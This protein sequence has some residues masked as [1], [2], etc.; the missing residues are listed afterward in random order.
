MAKIP[1]SL[2]PTT[3]GSSGAVTV[4]QQKLIKQYGSLEAAKVAQLQNR[5]DKEIKAIGLDKVSSVDDY[6]AKY[7]KAS[8]EARQYIETPTEYSARTIATKEATIQSN[9]ESINEKITYYSKKARDKEDYYDAKIKRYKHGDYSAERIQRTKDKQEEYEKYYEGIIKGLEQSRGMEIPFDKI[10]DYAKDLGGYERKRER[11]KNKSRTSKTTTVKQTITKPSLTSYGSST[12]MV[13]Q[14]GQPVYADIDDINA[15]VQ[16]VYTDVAKTQP[17]EIKTTYTYDKSKQKYIPKPEREDVTVAA[18]S[19]KIES[20]PLYAPLESITKYKSGPSVAYTKSTG[21]NPLS[22]QPTVSKSG[23][24]G[25]KKLQPIRE[26]PDVVEFVKQEKI[27]DKLSEREQAKV[28][29]GLL[30]L[31]YKEDKLMTTYYN[32][33]ESEVQS[34][35]APSITSIKRKGDIQNIIGTIL[36]IGDE[37]ELTGEEVEYATSK[38]LTKELEATKKADFDSAYKAEYEKQMKKIDIKSYQDRINAGEDYDNVMTEYQ[39][40]IKTANEELSS[41]SENWNKTWYSTRGKYLEK[42]AMKV[43]ADTS[44]IFRAKDAQAKVGKHF[45]QG[46]AVGG[47]FAAGKSVIGIAATSLT[48]GHAVGTAIVAGGS[49]VIAGGALVAGGLY[50]GYSFGKAASVGGKKYKQSM[51]IGFTYVQ[52][53]QRAYVGA[54]TDL[55]PFAFSMAGAMAGSMIV[56]GTIKYARSPD[57]KPIKIKSPIKTARTGTIGD[58]AKIYTDH[59]VK[60]GAVYKHQKIAQTGVSGQRVEVSTRWRVSINK[61]LG[62]HTKPVYK[63]VPVDTK[64]EAKAIALLKSYG[65]TTPQAKASI[66]YTAPQAI[67]TY[68]DKGYMYIDSK[69]ATGKFKFTDKK[70]VIDVDKKLGIKTQ[71]GE[72]RTRIL[73]VDRASIRAE[74]NYMLFGEKAGALSF[75]H[76][77]AGS[78]SEI[79]F[80]GSHARVTLAK[81]NIIKDDSYTKITSKTGGQQFFT[82]DKTIKF[83]IS[84][85]Y[86]Y[87]TKPDT[88]T[89]KYRAGKNP[90]GAY[91]QTPKDAKFTFHYTDDYSKP[92]TFGPEV[93]TVKSTSMVGGKYKTTYKSNDMSMKD[94]S[95]TRINMPKF[96]FEPAS[97]TRVGYDS[98]GLAVPQ[99][100]F[101]SPSTPTTIVTPHTQFLDIGTDTS[102]LSAMSIDSVTKQSLMPTA[103][104]ALKSSSLIGVKELTPIILTKS[105]SSLDQSN[106]Q[107][108]RQDSTQKETVDQAEIVTSPITSP[109]A[110]PGIS[111][112][113]PVPVTTPTFAGD[114]GMSFFPE[115]P[116]RRKKKTFKTEEEIIAAYQGQVMVAGKYKTVTTA[117]HTRG[118]A[119]DFIAKMIDNTT[120][121]QGRVV[122]TDKKVKVKNIKKGDG[123]YTKTKDKFR[124]FKISGGKQIPLKDTIIEKRNRRLD[125]FGETSGMTVAQ[126]Q[127][128]SKKRA[129]G[130]PVRKT[131]RKQPFRL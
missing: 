80:G 40:E 126:F 72:A 41:F 84:R 63:G 30:N 6:T 68:L 58:R 24:V 105:S 106:L 111:P 12:P 124:G 65:Y 121:A 5:V 14:P 34:T 59:G 89:I 66:K 114:P 35:R 113:I 57:L 39:A 2:Q 36:N 45:V 83:D 37:P 50:T 9:T 118:G 64:G 17:I 123:Y 43:A 76:N 20:V 44:T 90:F 116:D 82:D 96:R 77:G 51:D 4:G 42:S 95:T 18:L 46:A 99:P 28:T 53:L 131:K 119:M 115:L 97:K 100:I 125:T 21:K 1:A 27:K 112:I 127:S 85:T 10:M 54:A 88:K 3:M 49:T 38:V 33:L 60:H 47:I 78:I 7:S 81:Q 25:P 11:V 109:I 130:I 62:G 122:K 55:S 86:L 73:N 91:E 107:N 8:A 52:S 117:P 129:A 101:S 92:N 31:G 32:K 48:A 69:H 79:E 128:R 74:D 29:M 103:D 26:D 71:G 87:D 93:S 108:S 75:T 16:K 61:Y 110:S 98:V 15:G 120:A 104:V 22:I 56:G 102:L 94:S 19:P 67:D 23:Y 13:V 70:I